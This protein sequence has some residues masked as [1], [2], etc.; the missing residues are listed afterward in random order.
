MQFHISNDEFNKFRSFIYDHAGI[1]LNDEKKALVTSRLS[2]R[3]RF[4]ELSTFEQ[5]FDLVAMSPP[6]GERQMCIDLLTTNETYFFREPKH[7][8]FLEERVLPLW[9]GQRMF[10]VWSAASSSGEEAY[11]LAMLLDDQLKTD[12]WEVFGSDISHRIL[13]RAR[14]GHYLTDRIEGIPK[15]YLK[16][17]CLKGI[18]EQEGTLLIHKTLREKVS[19]ESKNLTKPLGNI[20]LFDVIF[21]RNVMIYFDNETKVK[22]V[23]QVVNALRPGGLLFIGHSESITG[24]NDQLSTVVPTIYQK[25]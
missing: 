6:G 14:R 1:K 24:M 23:A 8:E 15:H 4:H 9:Q 13:E 2:K 19:F 17:Y 18:E 21:L 10:R 12:R 22:I 7:F 20:G 3:L 16:T 11:S 25:V 5:Y